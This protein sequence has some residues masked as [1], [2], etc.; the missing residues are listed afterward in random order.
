MESIA[1]SNIGEKTDIVLQENVE[2]LDEI[3]R[4][5]VEDKSNSNSEEREDEM[6]SMEGFLGA[7]LAMLSTISTKYQRGVQSQE[8][9]NKNGMG[10]FRND[11]LLSLKLNNTKSILN[12]GEG[13]ALARGESASVKNSEPLDVIRQKLIS[14]EEISTD[15]EDSLLS[16]LKKD[17]VSTFKS[18]EG[19]ALSMT[20]LSASTLSSSSV[21]DAKMNA[22]LLHSSTLEAK[23][24]AAVENRKTLDT[25]SMDS[26]SLTYRFQRW[27]GEYSVNIQAQS[28]SM[29]LSPSDALVEQKLNDNWQS[30]NPHRW[31]L[32]QEDN[33]D[34]HQ[35][36]NQHM[37]DDEED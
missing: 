36:Q 4:S 11:N 25:S 26:N 29:M 2:S 34:G 32:V 30:G 7:P 31:H 12:V 21:V 5:K 33:R 37:T 13:K 16:S 27:G 23:I 28:G 8:Q 24:Q 3:L 6:L 1:F 14:S 35:S 19:G 18:A 17:N 9:K 15:G 10:N 22:S 20:M